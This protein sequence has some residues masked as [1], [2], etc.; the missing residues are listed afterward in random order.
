MRK[1]DNILLLASR[2]ADKGGWTVEQQFIHQMGSSYLLAH[3]IGVAPVA[4]AKTSF[5]VET[6]GEY[7]L[8]VR[9]KNWTKYWSDGPT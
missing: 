1:Q 3:G 4:D 2:F 6:E 8:F 5:H 9:T 7:T